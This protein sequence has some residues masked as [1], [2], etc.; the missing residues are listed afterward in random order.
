VP[1]LIAVC[2]TEEGVIVFSSSVSSCFVV[3]YLPAVAVINPELFIEIIGS[4]VI[5]LISAF[6][7]PFALSSGVIVY[8]P[9]SK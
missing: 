5:I 4:G 9:L 6:L 2:W 1:C 7:N 3:I 8:E